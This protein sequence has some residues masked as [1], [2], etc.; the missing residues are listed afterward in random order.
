MQGLEEFSVDLDKVDDG[1]WIP[2]GSGNMQFKVGR[3][4]SPDCLKEI[5]SLRQRLYTNK[6]KTN[7]AQGILDDELEEEINKRVLAQ[8]C[9]KDWKG[10]TL[11]GKEVKYTSAKAVDILLDRR[12]AELTLALVESCIEVNNFREDDIASTTKKPQN[13]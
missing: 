11:A 12:Y 4:G 6:A 8:V 7:L 13:G 2:V 5:K 3:W 9:V 1:V 10:V